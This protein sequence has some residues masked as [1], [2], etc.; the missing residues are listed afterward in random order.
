MKRFEIEFGFDFR[1]S[2]Q[3]LHFRG[4]RQLTPAQRVIEGLDAEMVAGH[5]QL[6]TA[7][8][9][10]ANCESKHA[11]EAMNAFRAF[12]LVEMDQN[13]GIGVGSEA[14]AFVLQLAA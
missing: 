11:V 12:L 2:Q 7:G 5:K 3:R 1:N 14:V 4:K 10:I 13:F 9:E 6:G 8:A